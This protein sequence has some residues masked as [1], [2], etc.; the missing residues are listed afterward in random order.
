MLDGEHNCIVAKTAIH[1]PGRAP[2]TGLSE[3][4][5]CTEDPMETAAPLR[6][7]SADAQVTA[8]LARIACSIRADDLP[9]DICELARQ[10]LLDFFAVTLAGSR[11]ELARILA[12]EATAEAGAPLATLIGRDDRVSPTQAALVNGAAAHA[13]DY[14]DVN[15]TMTG[16]PTVSVLPGLLALAESRGTR[17]ADLIAAFVSG[18]ET[19]CRVGA[20]VLPGHYALGFHST[21]T[22]GSFGAAAA[23]SHLLGLDPHATATA[24][25]IAGTQAAGLKSMFGTMCKP[26]HAGMAARNGLLAASLAAR[27]FTSRSDVLECAQGFAATHGPDRNVE[28]ALAAPPGGYHLRNNLFKYHAACYLTHAPIECARKLRQEHAI[29]PASVREVR[30]R[31]DAGAAKVCH[32][33]EPKTGL[34]AKFSLRLATAFALAG[35][36]TSRLETYS[37][38][39]AA[40][41]AL[42]ALR[43]K[44]T[45]AFEPGWPLALAELEVTLADGRR[46][47]TRHDCGIPAADLDEQARRLRTKFLGLAEPI[48][49]P[50]RSEALAEAV[51]SIDRASSIL[52][53]MR[54]A[55]PTGAAAARVARE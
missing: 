18:Y 42:T 33:L 52:E 53:V 49:G 24:F 21:G 54:L 3:H 31:I 29:E 34:E 14:D 8:E 9:D 45:V 23:A 4:G 2:G 36:D 48:L 11:E 35:V 30:L 51:R 22:L 28:A 47:G 5:A 55:R 44:V 16:H 32:I 15:L 20:L 19:A 38:R 40:N 46:V 25:G 27:G 17:G 7:V 12:Q 1:C 39:M 43:D 6:S 26:L 10:C 37:E 50:A 41:R 13:L